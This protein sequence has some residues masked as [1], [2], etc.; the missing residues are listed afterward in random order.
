MLFL[1]NIYETTK[2]I[3]IRHLNSD[4]TKFDQLF[5]DLKA[6]YVIKDYYYGSR[7][8]EFLPGLSPLD[9]NVFRANMSLKAHMIADNLF[10]LTCRIPTKDNPY[11]KFE[12][13]EICSEYADKNTYSI[14]YESPYCDETTTTYFC[15]EACRETFENE[16]LEY[17]EGCNR[18]IY[19]N[20]YQ[21]EPN[22]IHYLDYWIECDK[23]FKHERMLYHGLEDSDMQAMKSAYNDLLDYS[24]SSNAK[25]LQ[26]NKFRLFVPAKKYMYDF[27]NKSLY[28]KDIRI[29]RD[30]I[31]KL[32][33]KGNEVI[34]ARI[35]YSEY[36][37]NIYIRKVKD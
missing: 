32:I 30:Y 9:D 10:P 31:E 25:E 4:E 6:H 8:G 18:F 28:I 3:F 14:Y 16:H 11:T 21:R 20:T 12:Y 35:H 34:L 22:I 36:E 1:G 2:E 19:T 15:S 7:N 37:C 24:F 5:R 17:C 26:E 13:C 33:D 27:R 29:I 23:C